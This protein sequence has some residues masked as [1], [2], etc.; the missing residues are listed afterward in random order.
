M[1]ATVV[2]PHLPGE[3]WK[4]KRA[5]TSSRG[6]RALP[7]A[8][9]PPGHREQ[10]W[11]LLGWPSK[12]TGTLRAAGTAG[13]GLGLRVSDRGQREQETRT[14]QSCRSAARTPSEPQGHS[15]GSGF[16]SQRAQATCRVSPQPLLFWSRPFLSQF[17]FC[18]PSADPAE[19]GMSQRCSQHLPPAGSPSPPQ[20]FFFPLSQACPTF[21]FLISCLKPGKMPKP[22]PAHTDLAA[23]ASHVG[24]LWLGPAQPC[25][26]HCQ[27][28][29]TRTTTDI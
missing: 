28:L 4:S 19:Q 18:H 3:S 7:S 27:D 8:H 11:A 22:H 1:V 15:L 26:H 14:F 2:G 13:T 24:S 12:G 20:I 10:G 23:A 25:W 6:S 16:G 21:S 5:S 9:G 29:G 17:H